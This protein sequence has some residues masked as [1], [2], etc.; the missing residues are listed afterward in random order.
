[1]AHH[2]GMSFLALN[3]FL[4]DDR[5]HRYFHTDPRVR[6]AEPLLHERIP[7][8]PPLH[9]VS[10]RERVTSVPSVG[11][12]APSVSHFKTP[13]TDTPKT[14]LL[15]NGRYHL[16]VTSAGGGYSRW[17]DFDITRWRSDPT[18]DAWGAFCYIRDADSGRLWCNT[19]QPTGG[20]IEQFSVNF[21]LDH[22]VFRRVDDDIESETEI[23]VAPED[24][25]EI[26]RM[27]LI[28]RSANVRRIEITSY[29]E[30]ALAPHNADRQHPAFNKLFIQTEALPENRAL[31]ASRRLRID[32][33]PPVFV[34]HRITLNHDVDD[35]PA[36]GFRFETDRTRFIGRGRTLAR[37]MGALQK[38]GD[39]QG[40]V[41][42]PI[43][44]LRRSLHLSPGQRIQV[45]LV[46]AAA[47]SREH[48]VEMMNKYGDSHAIDRAME[49]TWASAQLELRLLRIQSDEAR[50]F[51]QLASHLLFPNLRLRTAASRIAENRKGQSG[52]WAY[53]ISGDL[54]IALV[55]IGE[56]RIW[57]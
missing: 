20:K 49:F 32:D 35:S 17:N 25:V 4:H 27:T 38:L 43:L 39:N 52:L 45:S 5:L 44:S 6:A 47:S 46:L 37:P 23:I 51:Q 31:L 3:N 7:H 54:P 16:M 21:A 8:L 18:R 36:K 1:M 22:A 40:F 34:A 53:S 57:A 50:R 55:A 26:R 56:T 28:N 13:H 10:T 14:Q 15:S 30:L 12:V 33:E 24:D 29:F 19:Y 48:V 11:E 42:D 2:Q 41:L 9:H